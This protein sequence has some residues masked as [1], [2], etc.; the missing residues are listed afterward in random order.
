MEQANPKHTHVQLLIRCSKGQC[1][2][3]LKV[4][5]HSVIGLFAVYVSGFE[6][7]FLCIHAF[8]TSQL[9]ILIVAGCDTKEIGNI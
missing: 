4:R 9:V 7:T 8:V 1:Y 5:P 3:S 2:A 6:V